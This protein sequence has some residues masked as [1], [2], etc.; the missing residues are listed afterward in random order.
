LLLIDAFTK[1]T[2]ALDCFL[3]KKFRG[4]MNVHVFHIYSGLSNNVGE[5]A[6]LLL[7]LYGFFHGVTHLCAHLEFEKLLIIKPTIII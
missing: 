1:S 6:I 4:K 3:I 2:I 5:L 7:R